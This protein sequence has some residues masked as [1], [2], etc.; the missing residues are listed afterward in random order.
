MAKLKIWFLDVG[1]GDSAYIELPNEARLMIDCGCGENQWPSK[2][3]NY[4]KINKSNNPV[5]IPNDNRKYGLDKL[6]IT[7]PHG[8]H[9]ANIEA[10]HDE[11]GFFFLVGAYRPFIDKI[12]EDKIDFRKRNNKAVKKFIKVIKEYTGDYEKEKDR[13]IASNPPCLVKHERFIDYEEG[14]D[15]NE[16]SWLSS[17]NIGRQKVLFTGDMT[18]AGITKILESNSANRF[19]EFVKDTTVLKVPHH[20][21]KNGCSQELFDAFGQNPLLCVISDEVLNERNEGTS[22]TK[23]YTDRTSDDEILINGT[24]KNRCVLTTRSDK[25]IYLEIDENGTIAVSTNAFSK[26]KEKILNI[27]EGIL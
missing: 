20:G 2:I 24:K 26:D 4:Y 13:V 25:D 19:K 5:P 7:H 11:I 27:K 16:L 21:R 22:A 18:A 8:D 10:I 1:H 12:A 3:L 6:L 9:I 17:L 23:W 14:I 15:L